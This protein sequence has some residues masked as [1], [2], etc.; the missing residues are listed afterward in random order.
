MQGLRIVL[1]IDR[2][3][4]HPQIMR[5]ANEPHGNLAAVGNQYLFDH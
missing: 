1:R 2:D 5:S 3:A 4:L